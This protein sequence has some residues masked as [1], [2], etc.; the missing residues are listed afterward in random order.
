METVGAFRVGGADRLFA[1]GTV[2]SHAVL[3]HPYRMGCRRRS[4]AIGARPRTCRAFADESVFDGETIVGG[5]S[6]LTK[7]IFGH[8]AGCAVGYP[9][10]ADFRRAFAADEKVATLAVTR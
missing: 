5:F 2:A 6:D 3:A 4:G 9:G 8:M 7:S 10:M 1:A